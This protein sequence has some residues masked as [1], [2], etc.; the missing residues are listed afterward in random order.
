M[1]SKNIVL[2]ADYASDYQ[3]KFDINGHKILIGKHYVPFFLKLQKLP[4]EILLEMLEITPEC[5]SG[6]IEYRNQ[7]LIARCLQLFKLKWE[8]RSEGTK[9]KFSDPYICEL[10]FGFNKTK[11]QLC[12]MISKGKLSWIEM[13]RIVKVFE[14]EEEINY[15]D[16][17]P[18]PTP[19]ATWIPTPESRNF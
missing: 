2:D 7:K 15:R 6:Y 1:E 13:E 10:L 18:P 9:V 11:S 3:L 5:L 12:T 16:Q 14:S 17:I 4:P 19:H 8:W